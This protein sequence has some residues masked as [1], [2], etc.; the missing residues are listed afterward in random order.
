MK[1]LI[2]TLFLAAISC[3]ASP[4]GVTEV[5]QQ[6]LLDARIPD[7]L[8]LDVRTDGEFVA[9]H[10]PGAVHIPH[11]VLESRLAEL[12]GKEDAPIVVYCKSGHRAGIAASV[13]VDAGFSDVRHLT[14]DMTGWNAA[15]LEVAIP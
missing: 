5:S 7:A 13:L 4:D 10:V 1:L 12:A 14:G 11:D 3:G 15:G 2:L 9:G 8:I 6:E